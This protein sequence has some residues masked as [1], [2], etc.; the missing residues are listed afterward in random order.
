MVVGRADQLRNDE[1]YHGDQHDRSI[2]LV[3]VGPV[4]FHGSKRLKIHKLGSRAQDAVY[5]ERWQGLRVEDDSMV[6]A[7][8]KSPPHLCE[9]D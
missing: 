5:G 2:L 1:E 4:S 7:E 9:G 3:A 6:G 8:M